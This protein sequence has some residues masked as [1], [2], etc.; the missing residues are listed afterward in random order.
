M[1]PRRAQLGVTAIEYALMAV[2]IA[3]AIVGALSATGLASGGL[4][5]RWTAEFISAITF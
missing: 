2:L 3:V 4:W 1:A 5:G